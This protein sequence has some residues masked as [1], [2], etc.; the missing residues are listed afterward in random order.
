MSLLT[1]LSVWTGKGA[2]QQ[3]PSAGPRRQVIGPQP[4]L[5]V[6]P[7]PRFAWDEKGWTRVLEGQNWRYSGHYR[8]YDFRRRQW[9]TFQACIVA[10][11]GAITAFCADPPVEIRSH[12]KGPCFMLAKSPWF[13]IHWLRQPKSIDEVIIY[14]ERLLDECINDWRR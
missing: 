2:G 4:E 13:R 14:V 3:K 10:G 6:A 5:T 12:P 11:G 1:M 9:R 8:V 7:P